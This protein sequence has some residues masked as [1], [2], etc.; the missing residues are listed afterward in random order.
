M[1]LVEKVFQILCEIPRDPAGL[2]KCGI[3]ST[4]LARNVQDAN[5]IGQKNGRIFHRW[6]SHLR[7]KYKSNNVE[8]PIT[9]SQKVP[10]GSK[11]C[12]FLRVWTSPNWAWLGSRLYLNWT[13]SVQKRLELIRLSSFYTTCI[14][15]KI[16]QKLLKTW[17][18][19]Q[20]NILEL[21]LA[22]IGRYLRLVLGSFLP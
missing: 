6:N 15:K 8:S 4:V 13:G 11:I 9:C 3:P 1:G 5:P 19:V 2:K 22:H 10:K 20:I 7:S 16:C 21:G 14:S 17:L 18:D 12:I